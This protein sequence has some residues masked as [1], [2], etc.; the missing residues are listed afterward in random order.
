MNVQHKSLRL[1][2][3]AGAVALMTTLAACGSS[4][5]PVASSSTP[6]AASSSTPPAATGIDVGTG[7]ITPKNTD[8]IAYLVQA[9]KT[10]SYTVA[11][12]KAAVDAGAAAGVTV[13]VYYDELKPE[14]E[15]ANFQLAFSGGKYG[16]IIMQPGNA[17]LCK[18]IAADSVKQ[19]VLVEI[20]GNALCDDGTGIGESLWAPGTIA[21]MG[22]QNGV[23][24]ITTVLDAAA[25]TH[26][27]PQ[28]VML[29][30]GIKGH[31]STVAWEAAWKLWQPKHPDWTLAA[32]TF[33]DF[34]TPGAFTSVQNSLQ[35]N[36]DVSVIF[37]LY[38]DVTAGVVKAVEA[39]GLK[40]KIAVFEN[41][42]G[43]KVSLQL[44]AAGKIAGSL[45]VYPASLGADGVKTMIAAFKGTQPP[46]FIPGDG[47]P[48]AAKVGVITK[49]TAGSFT[50][51]W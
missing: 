15:L 49:A 24:G 47:N 35:G 28:K 1:T 27:G 8:H 36:P 31:P 23:D 7:T 17:Q 16:G 41:G 50:A 19:Q 42:G 13:D 25:K 38:I 5:P 37:S 26:T 40:D 6:P 11:Q 51:L 45:P 12:A 20:V 44:L 29:A 9:T 46:K 21:Y 43:S 18:T 22:G 34:T 33:S 30:M 39:A 4:T 2:V 10:Y 14:T 3:L 48:D 32:E